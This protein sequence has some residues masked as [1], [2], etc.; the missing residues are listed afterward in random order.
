MKN[1]S[2]IIL[3]FF[4]LTSCS[5]FVEYSPYDCDVHTLN[6]NYIE[7]ENISELV[8]DTLKFALVSDPHD[9]Y[10]DLEDAFN[11]IN[12]HSGLQFV[13]C[14]GDVTNS[15]LSQ[16]YQWYKDAI[17]KS[18]YP[19]FTVIG[20]HDYRSNG[21]TIFTKMFGSSNM[22]FTASI[23]KFIL[24]DDIIWENNNARPQYEWLANELEDSTHY[25]VVLT[26]IPPW[27]DQMVGSNSKMY[28]QIVTKQNTILSLHGHD[29]AFI[30]IVYNEVHS[31]VSDWVKNR[32]YT[33]ITLIDDRAI[34]TKYNF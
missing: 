26:H 15:G 6:L 5:D 3:C 18:K 9:N 8:S 11:N 16:E 25:N 31:V 34:V 23:Y 21:A 13:V 17:A 1:L 14:C 32:N 20:N 7:A 12:Q 24:F 2:I 4:V 29:H 22:S 19:V 28:N 33:I 10:D 30:D 27:S